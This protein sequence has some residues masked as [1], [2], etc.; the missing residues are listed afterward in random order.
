MKVKAKSNKS[1]LICY[2]WNTQLIIFMLLVR[3]LI[4]LIKLFK[5]H[6]QVEPILIGKSSGC[7]KLLM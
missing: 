2:K 5:L 7:Q 4:K 3:K 1:V 6:L